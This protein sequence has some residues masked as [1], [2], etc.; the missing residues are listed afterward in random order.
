MHTKHPHSLLF[1]YMLFLLI[2]V[3]LWCLQSYT[4]PEY[5]HI[6]TPNHRACYEQLRSNMRVLRTMS[7]KLES[8]ERV[9]IS[10]VFN[11]SRQLLYKSGSGLRVD[12]IMSNNYFYAC[13]FCTGFQKKLLDS[14]DELEYVY[15]LGIAM[16]LDGTNRLVKFMEIAWSMQWRHEWKRVMMQWASFKEFSN[17]LEGGIIDMVSV[18]QELEIILLSCLPG[19]RF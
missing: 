3:S 15:M 14:I 11:F 17:A 4:L 2:S 13:E 5:G 18:Q 12:R 7:I 8:N 9:S 10:H 19:R 1:L 16:S 6:F